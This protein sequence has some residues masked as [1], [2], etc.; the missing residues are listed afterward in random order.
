MKSNNNL[1]TYKHCVCYYFMKIVIIIFTSLIFA[2]FIRIWFKLFW[3]YLIPIIDNYYLLISII[4]PNADVGHNGQSLLP[5]HYAQHS[6][7]VHILN[8]NCLNL[9]F[10]SQHFNKISTLW[11]FKT[12]NRQ[13]ACK[14]TFVIWVFKIVCLY[15]QTIV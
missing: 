1:L 13:Q 4:K 2:V 11:F 5:T 12:T 8:N 7:E 14:S 10:T 9:N 3:T 6:F 15:V